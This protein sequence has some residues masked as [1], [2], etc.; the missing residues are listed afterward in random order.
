M[1]D[2]VKEDE[3]IKACSTHGREE[4]CVQGFD[5]KT[6]GKEATRKAETLA[7]E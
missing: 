7:G 5:E 6:R 4:E 1:N 2:E 3:M